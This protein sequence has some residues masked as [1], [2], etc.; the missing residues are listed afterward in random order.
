MQDPIKLAFWVGGISLIV[1]VVC[2]ACVVTA[3]AGSRNLVLSGGALLGAC[4]IFMVQL[5]FELQE[6]TTA[7]DFPIEFT[8][9]YETKSIRSRQPHPAY[10]NL[11]VEDAASKILSVASAPLKKED[12]LKITGDLAVLSVLS[13]LIEEQFDWQLNSTVYKIGSVTYGKSEPLS[14]PHECTHF[15]VDQLRGKL[16]QAGN[17]FANAEN[18]GMGIVSLCLP[19]NSTIDVTANSVVLT[20]RVCQISIDLS[21]AAG[22]FPDPRN[23]TVVMGTRATVRYYAYRAQARDLIKYQAWAKRLVE[24]L[25]TRFPGS[26]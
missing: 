7:E 5:W 24:G 14:A 2:A 6:S 25:K 3:N 4:V 23:A 17:M 11:F 22:H 18:I 26:F 21:F 16:T 20:T 9:D 13:Y 8:T 15:S 19:P 10:R 1:T 12:A